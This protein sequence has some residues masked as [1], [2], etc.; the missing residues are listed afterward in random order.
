MQMCVIQ[1]LKSTQSD[2]QQMVIWVGQSWQIK[3]LDLLILSSRFDI[4]KV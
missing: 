3:Y 2:T 1:P 4:T